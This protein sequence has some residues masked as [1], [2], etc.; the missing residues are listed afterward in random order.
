M[1]KC[2]TCDGGGGVWLYQ[3]AIAISVKLAYSGQLPPRL[4]TYCPTCR[5]KGVVKQQGDK[6]GRS[7]KG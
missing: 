4:L 1:N 7:N 6:D 3:T 5:G 2:E